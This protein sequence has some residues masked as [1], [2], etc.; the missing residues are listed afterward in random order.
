[1]AERTE[2]LNARLHPDEVRMLAEI[3]AREGLTSS[4]WIRNRIRT[5]YRAI[6]GE[7]KPRMPR[8]SKPKIT[9]ATP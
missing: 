6:F 1:M 9:T 4:A 5:E 3:A 7:K 2:R 8:S